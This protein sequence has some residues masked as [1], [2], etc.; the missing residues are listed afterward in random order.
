M[1]SMPNFIIQPLLPFLLCC[2]WIAADN[3]V[4]ESQRGDSYIL[5]V[6]D[7]DR[8]FDVVSSIQECLAT[9]EGG[10]A[11]R[12]MGTWE[13]FKMY[14]MP[15][16]ASSEISK[17]ARAEPRSY[18]AGMTPA[19]AADIGFIVKTLANSS[20]PKI[21][22]AESSLKKAGDRIDIVH[23]LQFLLCVFLNEELK[24]CLRNLQGRAWVWKDFLGGLTDTLAEENTRGN[25]APYLS[26]FAQTLG[27]N[28]NELTPIVQTGK[29]ERFVNRLIELVPRASGSDR[30][31]M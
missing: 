5:H 29:W 28:V 13:S 19:Q 26:H 3:V 15:R 22:S 21:K 16:S 9:E 11:G 24:V 18:E 7:Q 31:N 2:S 25:I 1:Q 12:E 27:V 8:F 17:R 23:P 14:F 30:Y 20:L 4:V 10:A 6:E